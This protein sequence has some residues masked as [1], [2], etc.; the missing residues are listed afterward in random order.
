MAIQEALE[1]ENTKDAP[2]FGTED[3]EEIHRS[4]TEAGL[5]GIYNFPEQY[6][7]QTDQTIRGSWKLASF[8]WTNREAVADNW[9]E[10]RKEIPLRGLN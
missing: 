4:G 1:E 9:A 7:P 6:L 8:N 10:A 2:S 5:S 3:F